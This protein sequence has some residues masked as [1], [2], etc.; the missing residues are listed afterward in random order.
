MPWRESESYCQV[1]PPGPLQMGLVDETQQSSRGRAGAPRLRLRS[2]VPTYL[3]TYP[4]TVLPTYLPVYLL[5]LR[6]RL[7]LRLPL[8][9]LLLLNY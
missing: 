5:L 6:L 2:D 8:L 3:P 7:R 9:L 1:C 4:H